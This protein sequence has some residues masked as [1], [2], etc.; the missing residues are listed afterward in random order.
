MID[1]PDKI[2]S[3]FPLS[4]INTRVCAGINEIFRGKGH[5]I[6]LPKNWTRQ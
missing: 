4:E 2:L 6:I 3:L 1:L 5:I